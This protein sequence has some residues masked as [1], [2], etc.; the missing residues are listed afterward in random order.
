MMD[1]AMVKCSCDCATDCPQ[2]RTGSETACI[3]PIDRKMAKD[4]LQELD[5]KRRPA[6]FTFRIFGKTIFEGW[7]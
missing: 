4:A 5:R 6:D 7:L 1:T 3:I 2:G